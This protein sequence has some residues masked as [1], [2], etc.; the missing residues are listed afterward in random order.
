[1]PDVVILVI[2]FSVGALALVA[3]IFIPSHGILTIMGLGFLVAG[4][5]KTFDYA[6][7]DAGIVSVVAC[8]V[9]VPTFGYLAVKYWPQTA[10]GK[11]IA[12]PN[13]VLSSA[14]TSVPVEQINALIGANGQAVTVLRP[15]GI[16]EFDG[17][18]ISCVARFGMIEAGAEVEGVGMTG[19]NLSVIEKKA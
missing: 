2:L 7:R 8:G 5:V 12:P 11:L 1:V 9:A 4:V 16:C 14:D 19:T 3:E 17:R 6:G 13:P 18:R 10:I 15:V